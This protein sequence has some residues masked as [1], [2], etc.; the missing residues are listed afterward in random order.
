MTTSFDL[1]DLKL[2][3]EPEIIEPEAYVAPYT[4]TEMPIDKTL[5]NGRIVDGKFKHGD[6][7]DRIPVRFGGSTSKKNGQTYLAA[8]F[9][10]EVD[11]TVGG[12]PAGK[13]FKYGR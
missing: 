2:T 11:G 13:K 3:A 4:D 12:K 10:V 6:S 8:E 5:Y 9:A 7:D 1:T